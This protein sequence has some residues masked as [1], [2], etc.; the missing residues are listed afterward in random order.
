MNKRRRI[1]MDR[2]DRK[3]KRKKG[4]F[5]Y[6]CILGTLYIWKRESDLTTE[7][8]KEEKQNQENLIIEMKKVFPL[9][10]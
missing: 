10:S 7:K 3:T 4:V 6:L 8:Q 9:K 2:K 1:K 5:N